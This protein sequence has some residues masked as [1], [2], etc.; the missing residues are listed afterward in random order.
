MRDI[1][2][3]SAFKADYKREKKGRHRETIE[4]ELTPAP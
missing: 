3:A 1:V 2:R 4:A